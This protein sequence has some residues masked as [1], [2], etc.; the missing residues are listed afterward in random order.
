[1]LNVVLER[2]A[3]RAIYSAGPVAT[4]GHCLSN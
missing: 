4:A 1:M 2:E 3:Y